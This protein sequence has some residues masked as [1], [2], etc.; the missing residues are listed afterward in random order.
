MNSP[1]AVSV[2]TARLDRWVQNF[3]E[4]HGALSGSDEG[5]THAADGSWFELRSV[6]VEGTVAP[7][8]AMRG[9]LPLSDE[10]GVLIVRK[11]GFAIARVV[12][13][14]TVA[15]KVA[16]RHVQGRTKAGGQSQ[17]RFSR[18]RDNQARVAFEAAADHAAR[19]LGGMSGPLVTAGDQAAVHEVLADARLR[20]VVPAVHFGDVPEPRRDTLDA[21]LDRCRSWQVVVVNAEV[22]TP[23][24]G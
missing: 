8:D 15:S 12:A 19:V 24:S 5:R 3:V 6:F 14:A 23:E 13:G 18:R 7:R 9:G 1:R 16:R 10:W 4:R 11:G 2:P 22:D 20:S 17:Q 21:L